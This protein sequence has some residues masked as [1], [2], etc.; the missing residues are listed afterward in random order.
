MLRSMAGRVKK[1]MPVRSGSALKLEFHPATP[2]R[3]ADFEKLF[4][5]R[6]ACGGCW[7]MFQRIT[8]SEFAQQKGA[9][10]KRAIKKLIDSGEAPGILA[11]ADGEPIAWCSIGPRENFSALERSRILKRVDEQPVWSI[12]C[13]FVDKRFRRQRVTVKLL[14]A[15][16][17]HAHKRG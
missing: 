3:W 12:V 17:A 7:C 10:N 15:A 1:T 6:G 8:R 13:F 11:Y 5:E 4:G 2:K 16:V 9:G 14:E